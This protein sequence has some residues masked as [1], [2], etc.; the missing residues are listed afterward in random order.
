MS[1]SPLR[2]ALS[3][4]YSDGMHGLFLCQTCAKLA[5]RGIDLWLSL[6]MRAKIYHVRIAMLRAALLRRIVPVWRA[7]I[8]STARPGGS[9]GVGEFWR[10][11]WLLHLSG[12]GSR[13]WPLR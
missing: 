13:V 9:A 2:H 11:A 7:M 5:R 6:T 3:A 4:V 10:S 8:H 12:L 1:I